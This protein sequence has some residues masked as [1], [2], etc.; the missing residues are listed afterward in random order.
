MDIP[1]KQA[2][3]RNVENPRKRNPR[4]TTPACSPQEGVDIAEKRGE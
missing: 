4:W 3:C 1:E 2:L